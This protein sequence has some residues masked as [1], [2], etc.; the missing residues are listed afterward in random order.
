[1]VNIRA[2]HGDYYSGPSHNHDNHQVT[3][4]YMAMTCNNSEGG[5]DWL[6]SSLEVADRLWV[7]SLRGLELRR[8]L[9]SEGT[10]DP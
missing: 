9:L 3:M 5:G 2:D 6:P 4:L 8:K 7:S 1:M 10:A